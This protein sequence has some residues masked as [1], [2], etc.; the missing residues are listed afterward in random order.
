MSEELR[1]TDYCGGAIGHWIK[2]ACKQQDFSRRT[3]DKKKAEK[4][5]QAAVK[6]GER[7]KEAKRR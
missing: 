4:A 1:D 3:G 7:V 5:Q 2:R 6:A